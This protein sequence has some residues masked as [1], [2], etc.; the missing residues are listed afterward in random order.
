MPPRGSRR[1][2]KDGTREDLVFEFD[3]S[4]AAEVATALPSSKRPKAANNKAAA[5][6]GI[7]AKG[8]SGASSKKHRSTQNKVDD[9]SN[10]MR[11][12]ARMPSSSSPLPKSAPV[13]TSRPK[14]RGPAVAKSKAEE[15]L[16][17]DRLFLQ[18]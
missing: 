2:P 1:V 12:A 3:E 8:S 4:T 16:I 5:A 14:P 7:G 6:A 10:I 13:V 18:F 15:Q 11:D 9:L 17:L